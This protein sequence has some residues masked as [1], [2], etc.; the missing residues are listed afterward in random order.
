MSRIPS[1][2]TCDA[3]LFSGVMIV[4]STQRIHVKRVKVLVEQPRP[5]P[6]DRVPAPPPPA[7]V[8]RP[9]RHSPRRLPGLPP[10][11]APYISHQIHPPGALKSH[12]P[13]EPNQIQ[14]RPA[15]SVPVSCCVHS[16]RQNHATTNVAKRQNLSLD[17]LMR[18]DRINVLPVLEPPAPSLINEYRHPPACSCRALVASPLLLSSNNSV[19]QHRSH[20]AD[21]APWA[22][23]SRPNPGRVT[24][25]DTTKTTNNSSVPVLRFGN[26]PQLLGPESNAASKQQDNRTTRDAESAQLR[27]QPATSVQPPWPTAAPALVC[28]HP[29][30]A[31]KQNNAR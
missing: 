21:R 1:S 27:K 12:A 28:S 26:P 9:R 18:S 29:R 20:V 31:R 11:I 5:G 22:F 13:A 3:K 23:H 14:P 24:Q 8:P 10:A 16:R 19:R 4:H 7:P 6:L 2:N 15:T 25:D 30:A 17:K